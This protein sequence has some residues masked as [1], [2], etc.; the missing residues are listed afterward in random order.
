MFFS[1]LTELGPFLL[2]F[3]IF[4]MVFFVFQII[5]GAQV[6]DEGSDYPGAHP[7]VRMLFHVFRTSVGDL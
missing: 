1:V 5:L 6:P 7:Y 4:I 3:L 2:V